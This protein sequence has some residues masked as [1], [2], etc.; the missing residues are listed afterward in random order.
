MIKLAIFDFDGTLIDTVKDISMA[1][2]EFLVKYKQRPLPDETIRAA[3]G[4]GVRSL[5]KDVFPEAAQRPELH[6]EYY[7]SFLEIYERHY[8]NSPKPFPGLT[9]FLDNWDGDVAILSNKTEKFIRPTL[10]HLKMDHYDWKVILGGDSLAEKKPH[11]MTLDHILEHT[12]YKKENVVMIGDGLPDVQLASNT[13][14]ASI[15]VS[16]GY[17]QLDKL[18][19]HK[20]D[21]VIHHYNELQEA[22][23]SLRNLSAIKSTP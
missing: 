8:L 20:V 9:N 14:I 21:K 22:I 4:E 11:P 10:Q 13:N 19:K 15:A 7:Q 6:L 1:T 2:N 18:K 17:T 23:D 16:F 3:I 12:G 5:L